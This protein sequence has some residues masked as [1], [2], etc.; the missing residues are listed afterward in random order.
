[1]HWHGHLHAT[2]AHAINMMYL[3]LEQL[4]IEMVESCCI[5][6]LSHVGLLGQT[7]TWCHL[8]CRARE[9]GASLAVGTPCSRQCDVC[10]SHMVLAAGH[11]ALEGTQQQLIRQPKLSRHA[12]HQAALPATSSHCPWCT[13]PSLVTLSMLRHS[14]S[15]LTQLTCGSCSVRWN[16]PPKVKQRATPMAPIASNLMQT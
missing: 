12:Q 15:T 7:L 1:M 13:S 8:Q 5:L 10:L 14:C 9:R 3:Q 4:L 16:L 2:R 11:A 6:C